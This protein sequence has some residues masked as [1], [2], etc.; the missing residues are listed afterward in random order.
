MNEDPIPFRSKAPNGA[1]ASDDFVDDAV[2]VTT[3]DATDPLTGQPTT[4]LL[5][6]PEV[7][8][9]AQLLALPLQLLPE[10]SVQ[11]LRN[12]RRE[13]TLALA[14]LGSGIFRGLAI[15]LNVASEGL[16]SYSEREGK[17]TDLDSARTRR[18]KVDIEVE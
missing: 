6:A 13:A 17:I 11:H 15:A 5:P 2:E 12:A 4:K 14:D 10:E 7:D 16:K 18:R 3:A 9:V 1:S 8:P